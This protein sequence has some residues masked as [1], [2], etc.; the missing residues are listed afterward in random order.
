MNKNKIKKSGES[1]LPDMQNQKDIRN[2]PIDKAGITKLKYP[3]AVK[4]RDNEIQHT[5]LLY[6]S[7]SPRD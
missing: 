6:T 1:T 5:C 7:P 2:I 3:I 4:D